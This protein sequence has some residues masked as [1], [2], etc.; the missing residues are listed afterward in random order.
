MNDI[1]IVGR[2]SKSPNNLIRDFLNQEFLESAGVRLLKTRVDLV[3]KIATL[4]EE[5]LKM[6]KEMEIS[7]FATRV[8]S[9]SIV[10]K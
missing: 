9:R 4:T 3:E 5:H 10:A 2:I 8:K 7:F 1:G 6:Q